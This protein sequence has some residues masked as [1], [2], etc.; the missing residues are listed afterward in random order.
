MVAVEAAEGA[1][2]AAVAAVAVAERSPIK[3][4]RDVGQHLDPVIKA[5]YDR[6]N[7][8]MTL[9]EVEAILGNSG[10]S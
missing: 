10:P 9:E 6:I 2:A 5:K 3:R 4:R 8:G 7:E 1:A